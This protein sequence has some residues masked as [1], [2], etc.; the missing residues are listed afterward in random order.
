VVKYQK[1]NFIWRRVPAQTF[2]IPL[3]FWSCKPLQYPAYFTQKVLL[4]IYVN[5]TRFSI[6]S[7]TL[8]GVCF[9]VI[10]DFTGF[11]YLRRT[12]SE[13]K[14]EKGE[15]STKPIA[16]SKDSKVPNQYQYLR[17][18]PNQILNTKVV[19]SYTKTKKLYSNSKV[20]LQLDGNQL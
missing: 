5:L 16:N 9:I 20:L 7:N 10:G 3:H 12:G 17:N 14:T 6:Y 2:T 11:I 13:S 15:D 1:L 19:T 8:L 4:L 18:N